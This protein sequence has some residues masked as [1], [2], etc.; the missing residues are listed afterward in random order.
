M[1]R[2]GDRPALAAVV[3]GPKGRTMAMAHQLFQQ[4]DHMVAKHDCVALTAAAGRSVAAVAELKRSAVSAEST[5]LHRRYLGLGRLIEPTES[6]D[7][8]TEDAAGT[9][10]GAGETFED[11]ASVAQFSEAVINADSSGAEATVRRLFIRCVDARVSDVRLVETGFR[12]F[13]DHVS[14]RLSLHGIPVELTRRQL[15]G[16]LDRALAWPT[17]DLAVEAMANE[18]ALFTRQAREY[19][20]DPRN[21]SIMDAVDVIRRNL[22]GEVSLESLAERAQMS[23]SYFSRL[24]KHVVGEKFKDYL[25]NQRIELAKQLLRNTSDKVYAVAEAVGFHDHHY[26]SDV[27]KRKTGITPVEFRHRSREG[28]S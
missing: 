22:A 14:A 5:L 13:V 11:A 1:V 21:A 27:F 20:H 16:A 17:Y 7:G 26:F 3:T 28:E 8:Q 2:L 10:E 6:C 18:L 23:T 19:R 24:F 25:I 9:F 15:H 4:L 12:S